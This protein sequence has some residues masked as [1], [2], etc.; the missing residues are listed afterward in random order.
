MEKQKRKFK[1]SSTFYKKRLKLCKQFKKDVKHRDFKRQKYNISK[2]SS[3]DVDL[4]TPIQ[5]S[6]SG[7]STNFS[8]LPKFCDVE[9]ED[10]DTELLHDNEEIFK[11]QKT[12]TR[13]NV[14]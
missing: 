9:T 5:A 13:Y 6:S 4:E 3:K 10:I 12:K 1:H 8:E 2:L 14:Y 7:T 11:E